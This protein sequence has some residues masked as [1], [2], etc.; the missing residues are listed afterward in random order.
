MYVKHYQSIVP[1]F[2]TRWLLLNID[3]I[4]LSKA[5]LI[6]LCLNLPSNT[7]AS[8]NLPTTHSVRSLNLQSGSMIASYL[9]NTQ[10]FIGSLRPKKS[11]CLFPVTVREK[12]RAGRSVKKYF[13]ALVFWSKMSVLCMF[14]VDW[15]LGRWKRD[16]FE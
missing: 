2:L 16:F 7:H 10:S 12:N 15:E 13:F 6:L 9:I 4:D 14:Y 11:N 1:N 3:R 5:I 8:Y